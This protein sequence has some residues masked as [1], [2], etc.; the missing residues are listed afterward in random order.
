VYSGGE[1]CDVTGA[2]R[3]T[4][5][6]FGCGEAAGR[7]ALSGLREPATCRYVLHLATPRLCAHPAFRVAELPVRAI[8]CSPVDGGGRA[9]GA[10]GAGSREAG[11]E[12]GAE[13]GGAGPGEAAAEVSGTPPQGAGVV[14]EGGDAGPADA[15]AGVA[16]TRAR[17]A[18]AALVV[19]L[20]V[21]YQALRSAQRARTEAEEA[22]A[23]AEA[24]ELR[25]HGEPRAVPRAA[26]GREARQAAGGDGK[27]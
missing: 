19:P 18:P 16:A 13:D 17:W 21:V 20:V 2:P 11:A 12:D 23:E 3:Q 24:E 1:P 25:P 5:V 26:Q 6:R 15:P 14:W 8:L 27:L 10:G 22:R 9:G 7:D 4:E